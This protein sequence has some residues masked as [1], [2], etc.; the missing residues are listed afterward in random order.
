MNPTDSDSPTVDFTC[1]V[2]GVLCDVA[3]DLPARAVCPLHCEEQNGEHSYEHNPL[4]RAY[5]CLWCGV[6]YDG[7]TVPTFVK[8][9][10]LGT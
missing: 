6:R 7:D 2:C 8:I 9:N 1:Q 4:T 5:E 3:P 10:R